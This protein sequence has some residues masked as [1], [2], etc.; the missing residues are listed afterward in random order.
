MTDFLLKTVHSNLD[1]VLS[2]AFNLNLCT[3]LSLH[4]TRIKLALDL[5][6]QGQQD[7]CK[8]CAIKGDY[9]SVYIPHAIN[10][11]LEAKAS[12]GM[13]QFCNEKSPDRGLSMHLP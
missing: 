12:T 8:I 4:I 6:F 9:T 11:I 7:L 2:L 3:V 5:S 10:N 13:R 1:D